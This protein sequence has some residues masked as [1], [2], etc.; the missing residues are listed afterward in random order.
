MPFFEGDGGKKKRRIRKPK[1]AARVAFTQAIDLESTHV[2]QSFVLPEQAPLPTSQH[3]HTQVNLTDVEN[4][5]EESYN[6]DFHEDEFDHPSST[7]T[8]NPND[9]SHHRVQQLLKF[10]QSENYKR[11]RQLE[12]K[13]W[14]QIY[15]AMF[16][17]FKQYSTKTSDW[18]DGD[19]WCKDWREMCHC[20]DKRLRPMVLVDILC[21]SI[22]P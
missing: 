21:M 6:P 11:K 8:Q 20:T 3:T 9:S 15:Q 17:S 5:E 4:Q 19:K 16:S 18:G 22:L 10:F 7:D 12:E 13:N 1:T 2:L 14:A